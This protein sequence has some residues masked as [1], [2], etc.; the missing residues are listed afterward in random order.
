MAAMCSCR[1]HS[2]DPRLL[3]ASDSIAVN[4]VAAEDIL[5]EIDPATLSGDDRHYYDLL[6]IKHRYNHQVRHASD[7][8][9][10]SVV[11][12]ARNYGDDKTLREA[13][14]YGA[15]AFHD[16]GD[17]P[18]A[19]RFIQESLERL[20]DKSTDQDFRNRA[21]TLTAIILESMHLYDAAIPYLT[22]KIEA[23]TMEAD[24]A[25][26]A[27]DHM[28]LGRL[29]LGKKD[30]TSAL[31]EYDYARKLSFQPNEAE[32]A[33]LKIKMAEVHNLAGDNDIAMNLILGT[34]KKLRAGNEGYK[35]HDH[36]LL[37]YYYRVASKIFY[38]AGIYD[39]TY[40]YSEIL[41]KSKSSQDRIAGYNMLL[42]TEFR[43]RIDIDTITDYIQHYSDE[44][45]ADYDHHSAY[46]AMIQNA[47]FNYSHLEHEK[48]LIGQSRQS[49][50]TWIFVLSA[51]IIILVCTVV[52]FKL[53][54]D[55][56]RQRLQSALV[57]MREIN[58]S[59][60]EQCDL[61]SSSLSISELQ[62]EIDIEINHLK[63]NFN[64][65]AENKTVWLNT[66]VY[67]MVTGMIKEE[68]CLSDRDERW[69][70]IIASINDINPDFFT[71]LQQLSAGSLTVQEY[72]IAALIHIGFSTSD[73]ASLLSRS[74]SAITYSRKSLT[75]KLFG[76]SDKL[77]E[78]DTIL[79][80][81]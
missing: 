78:L 27:F 80:A 65:P 49:M 25:A 41:I 5:F 32:D 23:D 51:V 72:H 53:H 44:L 69:N 18:I 19:L 40:K 35:E 8:L 66:D 60:T 46:A 26:L 64:K 74:K 31:E 17:N 59:L 10:T 29:Y 13:L 55:K 39:S 11:D 15:R 37:N 24:S 77:R 54:G 50:L 56:K 33:I 12:W 76:S 62:K 36:M 7:S 34:P 22:E 42:K 61:L 6:I 57:D 52:I 30:Y 14:Y 47:R 28:T 70:E 20:P 21:L 2:I 43:D 3:A 79:R 75:K 67:K 1:G 68:R 71:A 73:I 63:D 4:P 58:S 16:L 9:I 48:E 81:L 38:D 45:Q